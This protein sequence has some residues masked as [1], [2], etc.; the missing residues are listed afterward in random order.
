MK[1]NQQED[2]K[3]RAVAKDTTTSA[4][5]SGLAHFAERNPTAPA[6]SLPVWGNQARPRSWWSWLLRAAAWC[7]AIGL[8]TLALLRI[9]YHDGA[10]CLIWFNAFTLYLYL[11]AYL[12]LVAATR[13]RSW[14]L[15][16]ISLFV[17]FCHVAWVAPDFAPAK[18][19]APPIPATDKAS[20]SVR[21]FFANVAGDNTYH[22]DLMQEIA[23]ADPDVVVIAECYPAWAQVLRDSPTMAAYND[24]TN[25]AAPYGNDV[26]V[27]SRLP[28]A[29]QQTLLSANRFSTLVDVVLGD[30]SLRLMC[31]HSPRPLTDPTNHYGEFWR[32]TQSV[33]AEQP[34]PLVVIGD[35]NATQHSLVYQQLNAGGHLRSAH[36][37]RGRGYATTWPNGL[38]PFPPI[39]IDQAM[40]S[41]G[42]ECLAI[43]E[44]I[45]RGSDHKP[46]ILD[47]RIGNRVFP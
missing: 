36:T 24:G 7:V 41:P 45:G 28:L 1:G 12:I 34:E 5:A 15:A 46:L 32:R 38:V 33:L 31:L 2:G 16:A 11:P 35:F 30:R 18:T 23:D 14:W 40:L 4:L 43:R 42:V 22:Q 44:G 47:V 20:P 19:Y 13:R 6:G 10:I 3:T 37:D 25:L 39:R 21:L 17:V 29:R 26:V 8:L 9:C 27:R